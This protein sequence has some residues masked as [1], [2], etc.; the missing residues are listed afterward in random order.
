MT[1]I[2][3]G[4]VCVLLQRTGLSHTEAAVYLGV[5]PR[6]VRRWTAG[7]LTPSGEPYRPGEGRWQRWQALCAAQDR[8]AEE[9]MGVIRRQIAEGGPAEVMLRLAIDDDDARRRG[10]P[11]RSA[12]VAMIR[13]VVERCETAAIACVVVGGEI[14]A[15]EVTAKVRAAV[16]RAT[17]G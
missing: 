2:T 3:P 6:T 13:R 11:C 8:A 1:D 7:T 17:R 4:A 15:I 12:H 16:E 10:L 14:E 9:A 5:E